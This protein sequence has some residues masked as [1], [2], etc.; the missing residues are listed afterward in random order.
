M[1]H[2]L[3]F[4]RKTLPLAFSIG[5]LIGALAA[6]MVLWGHHDAS[7][8]LLLAPG[9][10]CYKI[11]PSERCLRRDACLLRDPK[12]VP[13][14][15]RNIFAVRKKFSRACIPFETSAKS[16]RRHQHLFRDPKVFC[17][18]VRMTRSQEASTRGRLTGGRNVEG[19]ANLRAALVVAQPLNPKPR[20]AKPLVFSKVRLSK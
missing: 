8:T 14:E 6:R 3:R 5:G 19:A 11:L 17:S 2:A 16:F 15:L 1:P 20:T 12:K 13:A 4:D 9:E 7:H 18:A 10:R